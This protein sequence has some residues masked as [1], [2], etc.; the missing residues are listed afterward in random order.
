MTEEGRE[1]PP[2]RFRFSGGVGTQWSMEAAVKRSPAARMGK[3]ALDGRRTP[4][5][6]PSIAGLWDIAGSATKL[7]QRV[8]VTPAKAALDVGPRGGLVNCQSQSSL[9]HKKGGRRVL[10][11]K[12]SGGR[13]W[14]RALGGG[15]KSR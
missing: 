15:V 5:R 2:F 13:K 3:P 7:V 12:R 4:F 6:R 8:V 1:I 14:L 10:K 9:P 11:G